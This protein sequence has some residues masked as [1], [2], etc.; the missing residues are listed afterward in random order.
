MKATVLE[1]FQD[2]YTLKHYQI[3][4]VIDLS[5]ERVSDLESRGIVKS[6]GKPE[7]KSKST[8]KPKAKPKTKTTKK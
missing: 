7:S 5:E 6:E 4:Q 8:A 1:V 3:G 2:R